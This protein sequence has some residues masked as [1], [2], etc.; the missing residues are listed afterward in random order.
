MWALSS[1]A[2]SVDDGADLRLDTLPLNLVDNANAIEA[3]SLQPHE[4]GRMLVPHGKYQFKV[5]VAIRHG[6]TKPVR[7]FG[8][9]T[10]RHRPGSGIALNQKTAGFGIEPQKARAQAVLLG[11]ASAGRARPMSSQ[12]LRMHNARRIRASRP[13]F[14][15]VGQSASGPARTNGCRRPWGR[16]PF[17]DHLAGAG[18]GPGWLRSAA[19]LVKATSIEK[20]RITS[21]AGLSFAQIRRR[22]LAYRTPSP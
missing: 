9:N 18:L 1:L 22:L 13:R 8:S 20:N 16:K 3:I 4:P 15:R 19:R 11:Y 17:G 14:P 6:K 5:Q 7:R 2:V 12:N 21:G 10:E